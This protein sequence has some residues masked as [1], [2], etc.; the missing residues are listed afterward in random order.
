MKFLP[1]I[2]AGLWRKPLRTVFTLLSIT[3]AFVLFGVLQGVDASQTHLIEEMRLDRL[4]TFARF[5]G[6]LPVSDG[7]QIQRAPGV[8][9][10]APTGYLYGYYQTPKTPLGTAIR[11]ADERIF[12]AYPEFAALVSPAQRARL[13]QTQ[14]GVIISANLAHKFGWKV[15]DKIP[16]NLQYSSQSVNKTWTFDIV[17]VTD[18]LDLT[19][20]GYAFGNYT[21]LD[22][23]RPVADRGAVSV[24]VVRTDDP[25]QAAQ[26]GQVIDK[27]F[28]N[29]SA[30]THTVSEL[31]DAQRGLNSAYDAAFFTKAVVGAAF[32][33]LLFLTANTM[34]Q[35]VRER[36]SEFAVWKTLGFTDGGL[37]A[38]VFA[39]SATLSVLGAVAGLTL[40]EVLIPLAKK[41]MPMAAM[42][43]IVLIQG[44]LAAL[45]VAVASGLL[46]GLR[47]RRLSIVDALAGR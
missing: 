31:A 28:A 46:P 45:L 42:P 44:A 26:I 40:A 11:M 13:F 6:L 14:T 2:W 24:F 29:S 1:L 37:L 27:M 3:V 12:D 8:K 16:L 25:K 30:P 35:S 22:Q 23:N 34:M 20:N 39:E 43:P 17:A 33:T 41:A 36:T 7:D 4:Y 5:G 32:F 10:V 19:P 21:Y 38:L 18:D 47:A 9:L 15:G